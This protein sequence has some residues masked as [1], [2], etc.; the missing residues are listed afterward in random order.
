MAK[1]PACNNENSY[2]SDGLCIKCYQKLQKEKKIAGEWVLYYFQR[3][4]AYIDELS[5]QTAISAT[6]YT[7]EPKCQSQSSTTETRAIRLVDIHRKGLWI[8]VVEDVMRHL[9]DKR[10]LFIELRQETERF[11][12]DGEVGQPGWTDRVQAR[13]ADEAYRRWG[14]T[15]VP[16]RQTMFDWWN[17]IL[18]QVVRLAV[19][20]RCL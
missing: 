3:K 8:M 2:P 13:F 11:K 15:Y 20:Y 19:L 18:G 7:D 16:G 4:Q 10:A 14:M 6:R 1:C 17:D 5:E 12:H 9:D